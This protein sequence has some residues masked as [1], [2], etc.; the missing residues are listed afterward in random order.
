MPTVI[1]LFVCVYSVLNSSHRIVVVASFVALLPSCSWIV[2]VGS[3]A[4]SRVFVV[5]VYVV[6]GGFDLLCQQK[7]ILFLSSRVREIC[8]QKVSH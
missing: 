8:L 6:E 3:C 7:S 4:N 5:S 1:G 2:S